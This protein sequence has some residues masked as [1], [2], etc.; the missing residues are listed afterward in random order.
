MADNLDSSGDQNQG[1]GFLSSLF[2][3]LVMLMGLLFGGGLGGDDAGRSEDG[4]GF[5]ASIG[6]FFKSLLGQGGDAGVEQP[7]AANPATT[8]PTQATSEPEKT[9]WAGRVWHGVKEK[10]SHAWNNITSFFS[11]HPDELSSK[12]KSNKAA[13]YVQ[14]DKE[15]DGKGA[16]GHLVVIDDKGEKEVFNFT[17]G[18]WG[19]GALPGLLNDR[20]LGSGV[21]HDPNKPV[22]SYAIKTVDHDKGDYRYCTTDGKTGFWVELENSGL[23]G[24]GDFGIHPNRNG[25]NG[26]QVGTLGCIGLDD[27]SA[28]RFDG[29]LRGLEKRGVMINKLDVFATGQNAD[30]IELTRLDGV[31]KPAADSKMRS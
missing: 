19:G 26:E 20:N 30:N 22:T 6:N 18:P 7:A 29:I 28:R 13:V 1:G 12:L 24:R 17:S 10:A 27:E 9:S 2:K 25:A 23:E 4:G 15:V 14:A 21:S 8:Q 31:S 5:L 11:E 3:P 16:V